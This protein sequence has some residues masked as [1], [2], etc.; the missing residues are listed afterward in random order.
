MHD[1]SED[2]R[3]S[4]KLQLAYNDVTLVLVNRD[5][6]A[7]SVCSGCCFNSSVTSTDERSC[8]KFN[9]NNLCQ[10]DYQEDAI[11]VPKEQA[12]EEDIQWLT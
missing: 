4:Y 3:N 1:T 6:S 10:P 7:P 8:P 5:T 2:T 9:G 12:A 11:F